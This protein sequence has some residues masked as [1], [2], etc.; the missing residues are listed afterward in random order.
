[1]LTNS[2]KKDNKINLVTVQFSLSA[3]K[4]LKQSEL[5]SLKITAQDYFMS[6]QNLVDTTM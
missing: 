4:K 1:M 6:Q 5:K 2:I 3:Y